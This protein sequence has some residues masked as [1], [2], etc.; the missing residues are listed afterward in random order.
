MGILTDINTVI[1]QSDQVIGIINDLSKKPYISSFK[2]YVNADGVYNY[3]Y[4]WECPNILKEMIPVDRL[5]G[6]PYKAVEISISIECHGQ[7]SEYRRGAIQ[8]VYIELISKTNHRTQLESIREIGRARADLDIFAESLFRVLYH[9]HI[10]PRF[11]SVE[12]FHEFLKSTNKFRGM[13]LRCPN[14]E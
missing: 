7:I 12:A 5:S 4:I 8:H 10:F 6:Y 14:I 3:R 9:K 2:S 13:P 11:N 1:E